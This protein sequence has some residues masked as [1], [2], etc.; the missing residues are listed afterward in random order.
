MPFGLDLSDQSLRLVKLKK[1]G[2]KIYIDSYGEIKIPAGIIFN[3]QI[4]NEKEKD[5]ID[6]L[7]KLIKSSKGSKI[8]TKD[9]IAVLPESKTFIKVIDINGSSD[10]KNDL[11][12][13]INEEIKNHIPFSTDDIYIDWQI[14]EKKSNDLK[15]LVGAVPKIISDAYLNILERSELSP[16]IF[17]IEAA[18]IARSIINPKE[19]GGKIIIDFGAVRTGLIL[20]AKKTIQFTVSLP[21]SGNDITE[22]ISKALNI[23]LEKAEEAKIVCGLDQNKCE[24]ALIKV[25][26][27][28]IDNLTREIKKAIDFY[29]L[30]FQDKEQISEI[31]LCGGG[32]NLLNIEKV[33][34]QKTGIKTKIG[35][36]LL[37]IAKNN[38][39]N[40]PENEILSY[41]SAIG[42]ALRALEKNQL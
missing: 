24:G 16:Y 19:P 7:K 4:N 15:V 40:I 29:Q 35:N 18:A 2:K 21:I 17:E 11:S 39:I 13:L 26:I 27:L 34:S 37:Q 10:D 9:I 33:I 41:T 23:D 25:L 14:I 31:I 38:K 3:G 42:L 20:Y 28:P 8:T 32:A 22:T 6:L 36:P 5:L 30:N 12:K 1:K